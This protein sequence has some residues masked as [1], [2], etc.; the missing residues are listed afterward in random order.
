MNLSKSVKITKVVDATIAGTSAVN[1]SEVD[2][3]GFEGVIFIAKIGT[4]AA[5]NGIKVQQDTATG[6]S[7]AA[8]LEGTS[9][10]SDGTEETLIT[11]IYRPREQF[12]RPVVVRGTSTT[13]ESV[14]A[15]Q[16]GAATCPVDNDASTDNSYEL[17]V[18]PAEGTA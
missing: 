14:Y 18:S 13:V 6:M 15:I 7:G 4:A 16:Y 17:H 11:D 10:L 1:G 2:M 5:D 8:D 3:S 9:N 12:V